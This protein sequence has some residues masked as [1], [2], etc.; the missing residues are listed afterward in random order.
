MKKALKIMRWLAF[1]LLIIVVGYSFHIR[2]ENKKRIEFDEHLDDV[3]V[4]VNGEDITMA[5]LSFYI[6]FVERNVEEQAVVYNRDNTKD[7]WNIHTNYSFIQKEAK[8]A[9]LDMAIHDRLFYQLAKEAGI[10]LTDEDLY[11]AQCATTDFWEDMFDCQLEKLPVDKDTINEQI[12]I[13]TMA[14]KYQNILAEDRGPGAAAYKYDG[15][16]Y[17]L[18]L[19][20]YDVKVND[21]LWDRLVVGDITLTHDKVS[22]INGWDRA[23]EKKK[24][25]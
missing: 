22:Y 2:F 20:E 5:D 17:S 14:E 6:L 15:Y 3:V 21:D 16:E 7:F 24:K 11:Y 23:S 25:K 12:M 8:Y 19:K 4:T 9:I 1:F 18:I 13:A 10:T